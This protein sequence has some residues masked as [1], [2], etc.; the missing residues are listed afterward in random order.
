MGRRKDLTERERYQIETLLGEKNTIREIADKLGRHYMTIYRE[1]KRGTVDMLGR[2]LVPIRCYCAD[3]GQMIADECKHEKGRELKIANDLDFVRFCEK[4]ILEEHFSPSAILAYIRENHINFKTNVCY[5]TLY[6]YID[7]GLFLNVT[8]K[9]LPVKSVRKKKNMHHV[10]KVA[11]KNIRGRSIEERAFDVFDRGEYGHWEMDTVVG[12]QGGNRD[13]LL[14]L[15]ERKTRYEYIFKIPNKTQASVVKVLDN[16]EIVYGLENFRRHFKTI[17]MDNGVEFLDM[18]GVER[19]FTNPGEQRTTAYYCH[20]YCSFERGSNENQNK[21]VRRWV[22][23]GTDISEYTDE[24]I[25]RM[26]DWIN[27]YPRKLFSW[28]TASY[29]FAC[30]SI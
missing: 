12:R 1:I 14:V 30:E 5:T 7:K 28:K 23:K 21:L 6:S 16:L 4:M 9:N 10:S 19:S 13:C 27:N 18:L 25:L 29:M 22:P 8:N 17:T 2:D 11:K 3:R 26:Q 15:T 24:Y 20:P